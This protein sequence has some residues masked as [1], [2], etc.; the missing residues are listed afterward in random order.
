VTQGLDAICEKLGMPGKSKGWPNP[1]FC[2]LNDIKTL[3]KAINLDSKL[4]P[5]ISLAGS[6][7]IKGLGSKKF[8]IVFYWN[9]SFNSVDLKCVSS[10][11]QAACDRKIEM[12]RYCFCKK[13]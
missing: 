2:D 13:E 3:E 4:F 1:R 10:S 6:V 8:G 12:S 5:N 9:G 7:D 11:L